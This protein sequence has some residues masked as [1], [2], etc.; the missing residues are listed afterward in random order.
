MAGHRLRSTYKADGK[1]RRT[2]KSSQFVF[3]SPY[4]SK[5][6]V[7]I[8]SNEDHFQGLIF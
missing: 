5:L 4:H 8:Y 3:F 1:D 2:Y 6:V 7:S